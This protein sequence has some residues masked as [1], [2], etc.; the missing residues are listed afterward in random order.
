MDIT[1]PRRRA[2]EHP[3][4]SVARRQTSNVGSGRGRGERGGRGLTFELRERRSR[5]EGRGKSDDLP[6]PAAVFAVHPLTAKRARLSV[7]RLLRK[8]R[9]LEALELIILDF[10]SRGMVEGGLHHDREIPAPRATWKHNW[11][12]L[13]FLPTSHLFPKLSRN[14]TT[15]MTMNITTKMRERGATMRGVVAELC[16]RSFS[17]HQK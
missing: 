14:L 16:S 12:A 2:S 9:E 10:D 15:T 13:L 7:G 11:P 1:G 8:S 3:R 4:A 17:H 6:N 5:R